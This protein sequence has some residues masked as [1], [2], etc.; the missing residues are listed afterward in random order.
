MLCPG[1]YSN[2]IRSQNHSFDLRKTLVRHAKAHGIRAAARSFATSRNT[3]RTWL[4]RFE[5][6][7]L[8]GLKSRSSR[9]TRSPNKLPQRIERKVL[10]PL[11][12]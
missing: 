11:D 1:D 5:A 6:D 4:R 3:V 10:V 2:M 9:P 7:G 8:H 12:S